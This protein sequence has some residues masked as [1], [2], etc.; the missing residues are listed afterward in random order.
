MTDRE[1]I[2]LTERQIEALQAELKTL[3]TKEY[4]E[5]YKAAIEA[6]QL[7]ISVL[8]DRE[9]RQ[10]GCQYCR[11]ES[12]LIGFDKEDDDFRDGEL[13]I[14]NSSNYYLEVV[15]VGGIDIGFCPMCGRKLGDEE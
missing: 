11:M 2:E 3:K 9:E 8:K 4:I 7:A 1:S 12:K 6:K 5:T 15:N 10:E 14:S 13:V